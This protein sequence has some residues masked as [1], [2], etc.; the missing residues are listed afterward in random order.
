MTVFKTF[1]KIFNKNRF[2]V[3][4]YTVILISFSASNMQTSNKN[5]NYE[6]VKPSILIVNNDVEEGITKDFIKYIKDNSKCPEIENT[7]DAQD[8]ALF[9]TDVDYIVYIT[10]NYNKDLLEGKNPEIKIKSGTSYNSS[11]SE[12][13]VSRYINIA[14]IYQKNYKSEDELIKHINET[15]SKNVDVEIASKLDTSSLSKATYYYNFASYSILASLSE[16]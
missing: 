16:I 12:M 7:Q 10:E 4:L 5:L 15:L 1:W 13:I 11:Y 8:D 3:I 9:Y 14:N 6:A 2:T